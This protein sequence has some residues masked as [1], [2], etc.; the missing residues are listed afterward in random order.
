MP[1]HLLFVHV[2]G[3]TI[4]SDNPSRLRNKMWSFISSYKKL[5]CTLL[6]ALNRCKKIM[7]L[8]HLLKVNLWCFLRVYTCISCVWSHIPLISLVRFYISRLHKIRGQL[9]HLCSHKTCLAILLEQQA[10]H[11]HYGCW[12]EWMWTKM[13]EKR[14]MYDLCLD[15]V[16]HHRQV[17]DE[18]HI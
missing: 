2:V 3:I 18:F 8:V 11:H 9:W 7:F 17:Q 16:S 13:S 1:K 5:L 10:N 14:A 12:C 4:T 15:D 6:Y